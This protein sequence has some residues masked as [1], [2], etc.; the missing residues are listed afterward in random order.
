M[1]NI[2]VISCPPTGTGCPSSQLPL[3]L[4]IPQIGNIV[5]AAADNGTVVGRT[6]QGCTWTFAV[7]THSLELSPPGQFCFNHTIGSSYT[8]TRWSVTVV[9]RHER[10][11]IIGISQQPTGDLVTTMNY[12]ARTG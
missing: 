9:G 8:L 3:P 6:D 12:G 7:T 11:T 2:A 10:E 1:R 4:N 5:F